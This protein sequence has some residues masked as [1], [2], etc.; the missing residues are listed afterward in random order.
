MAIYLNVG[1][2][3]A[4]K[5]TWLLKNEHEYNVLGGYRE[6]ERAEVFV[7]ANFYY[8][9]CP[10]GSMYGIE[11]GLHETATS[12]LKCTLLF[13][14]PQPYLNLFSRFK[15]MSKIGYKICI[16]ANKAKEW[17]VQVVRFRGWAEARGGNYIANGNLACY[18]FTPY[19]ALLIIINYKFQTDV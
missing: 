10:F 17:N 11:N 19:F 18:G 9:E 12:V 1:A 14:V 8:Y 16:D 4:I 5:L 7:N 15:I 2:S 13:A 3:M 6:R